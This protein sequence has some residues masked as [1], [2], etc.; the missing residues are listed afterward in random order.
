MSASERHV[1]RQGRWRACSSAFVLMELA[2]V[3]LGGAVAVRHSGR[4]GASPSP[5]APP[6]PL[7]RARCRTA[8]WR[9]R[10][11]EREREMVTAAATRALFGDEA[12]TTQIDEWLIDWGARHAAEETLSWN[13]AH[14]AMQTWRGRRGRLRW[15]VRPQTPQAA[16]A[17]RARRHAL[18]A[19]GAARRIGT[20]E[21]NRPRRN[22]HACRARC[23]RSTRRAV[24]RPTLVPSGACTARRSMRKALSL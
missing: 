1:T 10:Q 24:P 13:A 16:L 11:R 7:P 9:P 18:G 21:A 12:R 15:L 22:A 23:A 8:G 2:V 14:R 17:A 5:A 19:L 6:R 3:T 4:G 20:R